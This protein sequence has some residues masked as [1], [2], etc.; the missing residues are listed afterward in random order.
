MST[1]LE[2]KL[3]IKVTH[4]RKGDFSVGSLS[5]S[6]GEFKVKDAILDQYQEG[7]YRGAFVVT[8]VYQSSYAWKGRVISD[9]CAH[10]SEIML[11]EAEEK[12]IRET[13]SQAE[14]DPAMLDTKAPLP[15]DAGDAGADVAQAVPRVEVD[16]DDP[17]VGLFGDLY[18]TVIAKKPVKLDPAI[19]RGQFRQQR[20][21]LKALGFKFAAATQTWEPPSE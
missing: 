7:E 3:T 2:G 20:D 13:E 1:K 16:S 17:D 11:V 5:T 12:P 15:P 18:D 10:V 19:D 21:R 4:G 8:Q 6:I 14:P 9:L